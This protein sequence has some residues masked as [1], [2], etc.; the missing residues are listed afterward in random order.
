MGA[1]LGGDLVIALFVTFYRLKE[2]RNKIRQFNAI[3]VSKSTIVVPQIQVPS[4][5]PPSKALPSQP[6]SSTNSTVVPRLILRPMSTLV[7]LP[8]SANTLAR[9]ATPSG[10]IHPSLGKRK[11]TPSGG[12]T[13]HL[14]YPV[15]SPVLGIQKG[16]D[17]DHRPPSSKRP[18]L[19]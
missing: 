7:K 13:T 12:G 19:P 18:F 17:D 5:L 6:P 9:V 11:L 2:L 16:E 3:L 4:P 8:S 10:S 1:L 15:Q 14:L